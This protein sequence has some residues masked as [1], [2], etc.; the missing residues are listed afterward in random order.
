MAIQKVRYLVFIDDASKLCGYSAQEFI[1]EGS[2][3]DSETNTLVIDQDDRF[4]IVINF[5]RVRWFEIAP[6]QETQP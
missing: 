5:D 6:I 2:T 1:G 4:K 3:L